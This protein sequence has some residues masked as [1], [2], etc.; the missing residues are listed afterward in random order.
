MVSARAEIVTR[1]T[2]N[3]P[4]NAEGTEFETWDETINR[5]IEHQRWLWERALTHKKIPDMPLH[6]I[7]DD[8][9]EWVYLND[10]SSTLTIIIAVN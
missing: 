4:T 2:Y 8:M 5:V 6:D 1:R 9:Y 7:T 10:K 3:R